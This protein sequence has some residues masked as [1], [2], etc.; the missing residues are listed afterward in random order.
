MIG[1]LITRGGRRVVVEDSDWR[2]MQAFARFEQK[3]GADPAFT[4][5]QKQTRPLSSLESIRT[6]LD[7]NRSGNEPPTPKSRNQVNPASERTSPEP[8]AL[9]RRPS[10]L[11]VPR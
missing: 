2:I 5:W 7:L 8:P 10:S 1:K 11:S 6:I 3:R 4:A 9:P